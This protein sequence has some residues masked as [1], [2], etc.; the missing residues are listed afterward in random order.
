[1]LSPQTLQFPGFEIHKIIGRGGMGVVFLVS[2]TEF[3]N[4]H[5][6][7][8]VI[9]ISLLEDPDQGQKVKR[10]FD[11]EKALQGKLDHPGIVRTLTYGTVHNPYGDQELPYFVMEYLPGGNLKE[12]LQQGAL[13]ETEAVRIIRGIAEAVGFAHAEKVVHRDIKPSNILFDREDRP[14][15]ADFGVSR[16][17]GIKITTTGP[18]GTAFYMSP[19]Q[20]RGI[21]DP[22][23]DL[24]SLGCVLFEMLTGHPVFEGPDGA[25]FVKHQLE[26]PP[27]LPEQYRKFQ[28]LMDRLL[29]K[30]L[31]DRLPSARDL[32][33][34][35]DRIALMDD[36]ATVF[37]ARLPVPPP[38]PSPDRP[39]RGITSPIMV[40]MLALLLIAGG[41][42]GFFWFN[43]PA[44]SRVPSDQQVPPSP[45]HPV[46][47]YEI[48]VRRLISEGQCQDAARAHAEGL[49]WY[50]DAADLRDLH[51]RLES[52]EP[53]AT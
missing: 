30:N 49:N 29:A 46:Q 27:P 39:R 32:L 22:R 36:R 5:E 31:E 19:E 14:K 8:K 50:P 48:R 53:M 21:I 24:Y 12:R 45:P 6:A 43:R 1:M 51:S 7:I 11:N 23:A 3:G 9:D 28:P 2:N 18:S 13:A 38:P 34:E 17:L 15:L 41:G 33:E 10:F 44:T 25:V 42:F 20:G 35:L 37:D 40:L 16:D 26:P 52:C 4:R 47:L